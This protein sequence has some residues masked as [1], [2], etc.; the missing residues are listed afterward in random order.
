MRLPG[1]PRVTVLDAWQ[2]IAGLPAP[3][4]SELDSL[5]AELDAYL[6]AR[7][8]ERDLRPG[9]SRDVWHCTV[10]A[11][12]DSAP[13]PDERWASTVRR[14][15][16]ATG[17]V[18][19]DDPLACRWIALRIGNHEARIVAPL[20]RADGSTPYLERDLSLAHAACQLASFDRAGRLRASTAR[21]APAQTRPASALRSTAAPW[22]GTP[23]PAAP[24]R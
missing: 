16:A 10:R 24:H 17:I 4:S 23:A 7:R 8:P 3:G 9:R 15:L 6:R 13:L 2:P 21:T 20:M 22:G 18:P 14:I 19:V 5:A 11:H 12:P 1:T